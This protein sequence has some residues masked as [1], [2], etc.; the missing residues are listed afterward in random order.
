MA[1]HSLARR[2]ITMILSSTRTVACTGLAVLMLAG[3]S[4]AQARVDAPTVPRVPGDRPWLGVRYDVD[5]VSDQ[6]AW[7]ELSAEYARPVGNAMLIA[8]ARR[9]R[10]F[11]LSG[12]QVEG[13]AY[14]R[15]GA[16]SY[17][18]LGAAVS[19]SGSVYPLT[20]FA[21]EAYRALPANFETSMGARYMLTRNTGL[22]TYT[23][24]VAR[25]MGDYWVSMRPSLTLYRGQRARSLAGVARRYF[26]GRYDYV[27]LSAS[28]SAGADPEA[29]DP[30]RLDRSSDLQGWTLHLDRLQ[31]LGRDARVRYG[32][33]YEREEF[34][35][36]AT[37]S[38]RTM[39]LGID[40]VMP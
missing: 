20:R 34:A 12:T 8:R 14:P 24:T 11:G 2:R 39:V 4:G 9:A 28:A 31:P 26:S 13:E 30:Q 23:G 16:R 18:Y 1:T 19:P 3:A 10:R 6:E 7:H 15:L 21:A 25:Y 40:W 37:R 32:A 36:G 35:P 22:A 17:L 33:G 38:H 27:S 29:R 5:A